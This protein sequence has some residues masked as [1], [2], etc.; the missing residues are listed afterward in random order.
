MRPSYVN[1]I[2][3]MNF[4]KEIRCNLY[5]EDNEQIAATVAAIYLILVVMNLFQET[6]K[7]VFII[8][9]GWF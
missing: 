3:K 6:K 4:S 8:L 9:L 7:F 2:Y 5:F 1:L